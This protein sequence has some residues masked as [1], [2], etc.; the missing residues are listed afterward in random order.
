MIWLL[1]VGVGDR[2]FRETPLHGEVILSAD[3]GAWRVIWSW[4]VGFGFL[5]WRQGVSRNAPT[6]CGDLVGG[7]RC[8]ARDVVGVGVIWL[9][10]L[11]TGRFAKRPYT[12]R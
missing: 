11:A 12:V 4:S 3:S 9:L 1:G 6:R 2:A 10:G 8:V 5:D 7:F